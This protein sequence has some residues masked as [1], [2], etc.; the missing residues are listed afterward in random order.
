MTAMY[1]YAETCLVDL[2]GGSVRG[3][4]RDM[5]ATAWQDDPLTL[6]AYSYALPHELIST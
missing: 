2:F 3:A 5:I 4:I 6:G 1:D